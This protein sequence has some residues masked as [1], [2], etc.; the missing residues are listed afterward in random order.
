MHVTDRVLDEAGPNREVLHEVGHLEE[1]LTEARVAP[2][3]GVGVDR[4]DERV[5]DLRPTRLAH[6][7]LVDHGGNLVGAEL[8]GAIRSGA[9]R[10]STVRAGTARS[11]VRA[12]VRGHAGTPTGISSRRR[13]DERWPGSTSSRLGTTVSHVPASACGQ[14]GLNAHPGG[15]KISDGGWPLMR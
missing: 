11:T 15:K 6:R 8:L 14:R 10:S 13:H 1:G 9:A 2:S 5:G 12:V 7:R 3:D 4:R